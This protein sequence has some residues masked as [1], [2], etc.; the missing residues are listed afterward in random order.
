MLWLWA[1]Y[2]CHT[3]CLHEPSL[4]TVALELIKF[5]NHLCLWSAKWLDR[6]CSWSN[7][8]WGCGDGQGESSSKWNCCCC[9]EDAPVWKRKLMIERELQLHV[10]KSQHMSLSYPSV[11]FGIK[12]PFFPEIWKTSVVSVSGCWHTSPWLY[13]YPLWNTPHLKKYMESRF[14]QI[15][16]SRFFLP[17]IQ[18][19]KMQH[20]HNTLRCH[21]IV[22]LSYSFQF[23][24]SFRHLSDSSKKQP[25]IVHSFLVHSVTK[26]HMARTLQ[27]LCVYKSSN[28]YMF[29]RVFPCVNEMCT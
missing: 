29:I 25:Q 13:S 22:T 6:K 27:F 2:E 24:P 4:E 11:C 26:K 23:S 28:F 21:L 9:S 15:N 19:K 12:V 20:S 1:Y 7:S 16:L 10:N 3:F 5:C 14:Y 17:K 18:A 8:E